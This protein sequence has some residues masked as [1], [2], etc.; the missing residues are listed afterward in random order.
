M[1]LDIV[2]HGRDFQRRSTR[3][4][5]NLSCTRCKEIR[6]MTR[7]KMTKMTLLKSIILYLVKLKEKQ[8]IKAR[9]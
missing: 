9:N 7:I 2:K 3:I 5:F 4:D 8:R 1:Q 6:L